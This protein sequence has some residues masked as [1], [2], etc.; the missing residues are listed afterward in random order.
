MTRLGAGGIVPPRR[1]P[2][3]PVGAG[4]ALEEQMAR[5]AGVNEAGALPKSCAPVHAAHPMMK[6]AD[7]MR[8]DG[9]REKLDRKRIPRRPRPPARPR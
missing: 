3:A 8:I 9:A 2:G 7:F 5:A 1:A 6:M 4:W